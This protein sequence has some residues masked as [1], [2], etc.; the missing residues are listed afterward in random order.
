MG[1]VMA[2]E[3]VIGLLLDA[4]PAARQALAHIDLGKLEGLVLSSAQDDETNTGF[5]ESIEAM[6]CRHPAHA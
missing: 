1:R 2:L 5:L 3:F 6:Q 4:A